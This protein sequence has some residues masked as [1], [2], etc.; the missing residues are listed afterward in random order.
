[1]KTVTNSGLRKNFSS[2]VITVL[3]SLFSFS[4]ILPFIWM[5]SA[6]IKIG[7]DVIKLPIKWIPDYFYP[8]NYYQ[9]WN[10]GGIA[11]RNYHFDL[12]YFNSL[13][14]AIINM[15]GAIITSAAAGYAFAKI[16][17]RV[18]TGCGPQ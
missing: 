7:A 4:M 2:I 10:I 6:S 3:V 14:I 8:D 17:F 9:I 12:A 15:T 13:K 18:K 1:M 5:L 11:K 16:S